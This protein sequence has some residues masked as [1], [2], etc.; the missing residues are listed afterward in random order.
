MV[1]EHVNVILYALLILLAQPLKGII[2][3]GESDI[4]AL[5]P[6]ADLFVEKK[7]DLWKALRKF[8][9]K[10]A[11]LV[12]IVLYQKGSMDFKGL[13]EE[14]KLSINTLNHTLIEMRNADLII[15]QDGDYYLT[16]YGAIL[17]SALGNMKEEIRKISDK[18]LLD[19]I[20]NEKE[21]VH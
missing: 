21:I 10:N 8:S 6:E 18:T 13:R 19:P 5:T 17:L 11:T 9:N 3:G 2:R 1:R 12:A 4:E 15:L 14:T 20:N 7:V 16:K